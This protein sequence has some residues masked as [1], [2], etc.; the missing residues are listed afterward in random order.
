MERER[1]SFFL[2]REI[3]MS[4]V[5]GS[6]WILEKKIKLIKGF[7]FGKVGWEG[8]MKKMNFNIKEF[9]N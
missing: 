6:T 5:L 7:Y 1:E 3:V 9:V 2:K 8:N 4:K